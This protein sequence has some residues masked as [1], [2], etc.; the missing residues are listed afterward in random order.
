MEETILLPHKIKSKGIVYQDKYKK[1]EK[2]QADFQGFKK[3]YFVSDYGRKAAVVIVRD[4]KILL[5]RQYR[6]LING[7]SYEIPGGKIN[8]K[9]PPEKA[10]MRE[11][12][13]ETGMKC[14]GLKRL[15]EF[16]PDLEYSRN[17]TYVFVA[18]ATQG[19]LKKEKRSVWV[20]IKR[21]REMVF[22]GKIS[23]S[24]TVIS[25]LAYLTKNIK[26]KERNRS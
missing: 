26:R 7:L 17:H 5:V 21:C 4:N 16:D 20:S 8:E 2:I 24:L 19:M 11:C 9:E 6:L 3:E 10:A 23:D 22:S 12:L 15:I 25:V 14:S 18:K 1:I 13:E